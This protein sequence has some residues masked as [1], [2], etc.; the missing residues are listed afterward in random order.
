MLPYKNKIE[1]F[2]LE[3]TLK[4]TQLQP[5]AMGRAAPHQLRIPRAPSNLA[6]SIQ[7]WGTT[8]SLG[9]CASASPH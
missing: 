4:P 1:W 5:P 7:G 6:L 8:A 9:S 2:V 3:E